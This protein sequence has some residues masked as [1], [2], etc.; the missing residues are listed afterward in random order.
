MPALVAFHESRFPTKITLGATGGPER[1][2]EIV[3]LGQGHEA[4]NAR[5]ADSRRR[6]DAG[7]GLRTLEDLQAVVRFFEERRGRLHGFR[8]RD[9][10]DYR[11]SAVGQATSALDQ[12]LGTGDGLTAAFQLVKTYGAGSTAYRRVIAKPVSGTVK[13]AVAGVTRTIGPQ[14]TVN[15]A[16]GLLTFKDGFIPAPGQAVTAGF[17]FDVPVRF[18]TDRLTIDLSHFEAGHIP[19]I[20]L[21]EI[22]P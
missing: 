5:F 6:Y 20:P 18:D 4:R 15:T 17:D 14:V 13:V 12:S 1:V 3:A 9:P 11:S 8:Y 21:V 19:S 10:L 2:T 7:T 22:R 16:T